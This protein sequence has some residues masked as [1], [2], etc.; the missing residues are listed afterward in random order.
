MNTEGLVAWREGQGA[1]T[2]PSA[3][4]GTD[5]VCVCVCV[6][7][8]VG[9]LINVPVFLSSSFSP[10][11]ESASSAPPVGAAFPPGPQQ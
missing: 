3:P 1:V 7:I 8:V 11:D 5:S 2:L 9:Q 4:D 6:Y 10:S